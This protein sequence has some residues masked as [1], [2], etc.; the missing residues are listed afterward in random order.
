MLRNNSNSRG[1]T[2]SCVVYSL[3]I[4]SRTVVRF[5]ICL[6][7]SQ[8]SDQCFTNH[9]ATVKHHHKLR[10]Q[11]GLIQASEYPLHCTLFYSFSTLFQHLKLSLNFCFHSFLFLLHIILPFQKIYIKCASQRLMKPPISGAF[12][13]TKTLTLVPIG[14][15]VQ[16][17]LSQYKTYTRYFFFKKTLF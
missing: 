11:P 14:D 9:N 6:C 1:R 4:S 5:P 3:H 15:I 10:C 8:L 7:L 12:T 17:F 16:G 13:G 2:Q